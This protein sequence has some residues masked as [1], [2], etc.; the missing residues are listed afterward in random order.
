MQEHV[1]ADDV[2]ELRAHRLK[3][4]DVL[5]VTRHISSCAACGALARSE[6]DAPEVAASLREELAPAP[7]AWFA[8]SAVAAV[9][10]I[11]ITALLVLRRQPA[12]APPHPSRALDPTVVAAL[13]AGRIDP[14]SALI[15]VRAQPDVL[16][17]YTPGD[18]G[19]IE[20]RGVVVATTTPRFLWTGAGRATVSVYDGNDLAAKS[21]VLRASEWTPPP[22]PRGRTYTWQVELES[23]GGRRFIPAPPDPPA[24]FAIVDAQSWSAIERAQR[25]NDPLTAAVL[26]ARAG[27]K[28]ESLADFDA[29]LSNH[30]GDARVRALAHSV[31]AW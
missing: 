23:N 17:G 11:A 7:R 29:Y 20:P 13:R 26:E 15:A 21:G 22:L 8:W 25:A 12:P 3:A 4:A 31:S 14:P 27:L 5:R 6:I 10:L 18:E 16:R 9:V 28:R 2:R 24:L 19:R 30:P 1:T